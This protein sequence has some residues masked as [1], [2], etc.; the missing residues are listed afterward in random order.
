MTKGVREYREDMGG[1]Q[2]VGKQQSSVESYSRSPMSLEGQRGLSKICQWAAQ[3]TKI[4]LKYC[5]NKL[6]IT[7]AAVDNEVHLK[8]VTFFV[9]N[10]I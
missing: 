5:A 8:N 9:V 6:Q 1:G 2:T 10:V 4:S 7:I 3:E